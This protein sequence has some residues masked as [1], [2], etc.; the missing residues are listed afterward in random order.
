MYKFYMLHLHIIKQSVPQNLPPPWAI[1][2]QI[3]ARI[4]LRIAFYTRH[5]LYRNNEEQ[6]EL[7][8]NIYPS[9]SLVI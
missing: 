2:Y 8:K 1:C 4:Q 7:A 6:A 9:S 5:K 3:R